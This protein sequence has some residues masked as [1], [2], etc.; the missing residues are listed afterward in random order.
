MVT[1]TTTVSVVPEEITAEDWTGLLR[2]NPNA[3]LI[4]PSDAVE[5]VIDA[6][7]PKLQA[8]VCRCAGAG[9]SLPEDL[10][11]TLIVDEVAALSAD[12]Q[13]RL[14]TWLIEPGRL[15]QVLATASS[16]LFPRVASGGFLDV[17]YYR[18]NVM[19]FTLGTGVSA[20]AHR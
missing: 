15:T 3:L 11:G 20:S 5:H 10:G 4:G 13:R 9:L 6:L 12:D 8:P 2:T 19:S 18:L 1:K 14:L 17:L 7:G 16:A